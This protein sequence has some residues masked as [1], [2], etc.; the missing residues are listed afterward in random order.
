MTEL[1]IEAPEEVR[2][3]LCLALDTDDLVEAVAVVGPR[4]EIAGRLAARAAGLTDS[5]GL[6]NSRHPDPTHFADIV[7]D[8]RP[9]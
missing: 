8:L 9:R 4:D 1:Q 5:V 7:T 3:R 6:V 2:D